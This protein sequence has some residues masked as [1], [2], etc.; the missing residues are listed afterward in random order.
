MAG[1]YQWRLPQYKVNPLSVSQPPASRCADTV[2]PTPSDIIYNRYESQG[3]GNTFGQNPPC[4]SHQRALPLG[5]NAPEIHTHFLIS[6][7]GHKCVRMYFSTKNR[8]KVS[9][10]VLSCGRIAPKTHHTH[11]PCM[12]PQCTTHTNK[13]TLA[14]RH[15]PSVAHSVYKW[16]TDITSTKNRLTKFFLATQCLFVCLFVCLF[17]C[18]FVFSQGDEIFLVL[19]LVILD[20]M[21]NVAT[22]KKKLGAE[23]TWG[24]T[25]S[26]REMITNVN[27]VWRDSETI[28]CFQTSFFGKHSTIERTAGSFGVESTTFKFATSNF[29][30]PTC[31][32]FSA[33]IQNHLTTSLDSCELFPVLYTS[34]GGCNLWT[35]L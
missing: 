25:D 12:V 17:F 19:V 22:R 21:S 27:D 8:E 4:G 23:E 18:L 34:S 14:H 6:F 35:L 5:F 9:V 11:Q 31:L 20:N 16:M 29:L 33:M 1:A 32:F 3:R 24:G 28:I 10:P 7:F 15:T 13:L 30:C 2:G 26:V